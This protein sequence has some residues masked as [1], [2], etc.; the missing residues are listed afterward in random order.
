[1]FYDIESDEFEAKTGSGLSFRGGGSPVH[2]FRCMYYCCL[3][4]EVRFEQLPK[5]ILANYAI[6]VKARK[7]IQ[8]DGSQTSLLT[9][10]ITNDKG[11][12]YIL[13][14]AVLLAL[15]AIAGRVTKVSHHQRFQPS[16]YTGDQ[17]KSTNSKHWT[18]GI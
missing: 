13:I 2:P 4:Y 10:A 1:M 18:A 9:F 5:E 15:I 14:L 6:L 12:K 16:T 3:W 11:L 7:I 8:M 17:Y